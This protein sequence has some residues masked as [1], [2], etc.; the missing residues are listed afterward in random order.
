MKYLLNSGAYF[1]Q[2]Y[3]S[4]LES[5]LPST[6]VALCNG[7]QSSNKFQF[8]P[9]P[10]LPPAPGQLN[11]PLAP[12]KLPHGGINSSAGSLGTGKRQRPS[13]PKASAS[14]D[15]KHLFSDLLEIKGLSSI[16]GYMSICQFSC[17][18]CQDN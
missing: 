14:S 9:F 6:P 4:T 8:K 17:K 11:G 16:Y 3:I 18:W 2:T 10:P 1:S 15:S 7:S 12:R 5:S 13:L